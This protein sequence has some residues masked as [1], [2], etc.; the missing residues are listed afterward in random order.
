MEGHSKEGK[1]LRDNNCNTLCN[2]ALRVHHITACLD[3]TW[4]LVLSTRPWIANITHRIQ[5]LGWKIER[6][7]AIP[8][9]LITRA[10]LSLILLD[11]F[12]DP[13]DAAIW[14]DPLLWCPMRKWRNVHL[15]AASASVGVSVLNAALLYPSVMPSRDCN[16]LSVR[17]I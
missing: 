6:E 14:Q 3:N 10:Q 9:F 11:Y 2:T 15:S 8:L 16:Y 5:G 17:W 7:H 4:C 1:K 13:L 12:E